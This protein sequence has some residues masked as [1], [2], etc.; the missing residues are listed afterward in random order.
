MNRRRRQGTGLF[1]ALVGGI[2]LATVSHVSQA[3]DPRTFLAG[4]TF[5]NGGFL[6]DPHRFGMRDPATD[7]VDQYTYTDNFDFHEVDLVTND[8]TGVPGG[9]GPEVNPRFLIY[10]DGDPN[11]PLLDREDFWE[12][13]V[14]YRAPA[15]VKRWVLFVGGAFPPPNPESPAAFATPVTV[16]WT[17]GTTQEHPTD[18]RLDLAA[19]PA[20]FQTVHMYQADLATTAI[21]TV[22]K[23]VDIGAEVAATRVDMRDTLGLLDPPNQYPVAINRP[24]ILVIE[25]KKDV[26]VIPE[27]EVS[28]TV[29]ITAGGA[30]APQAL[31]DA[32]FWRLVGDHL[33]NGTTG[34]LAPGDTVVVPAGDVTLVFDDVCGY[35][36][37]A[38]VPLTLTAL[39]PVQETGDYT[40]RTLGTLTVNIG[41]PEV[42]TVFVDDDPEVPYA[43]WEAFIPPSSSFQGYKASGQ[44]VSLCP[45]TWAVQFYDTV[46]GDWIAPADI[47][48]DIDY[49]DALVRNVVYTPK[50]IDVTVTITPQAAIDDGAQWTID[51]GATWHV[52]GAAGV[53]ATPLQAYTLAFRDVAGWTTPPN[54]P[55]TPDP[56]TPEVLQGDYTALADVTATLDGLDEFFVPGETVQ[57][58]GSFEYPGDQDLTALT[59]NF[60]LPTGWT[61]DDVSGDASV[62]DIAGDAIVFPAGRGLASNPVTFTATLTTSAA[63]TGDLD[64]GST[65]DYTPDFGGTPPIVLPAVTF[66]E[67]TTHPADT[68]H[69][70]KIKIFEYLVYAG[71]VAAV[72]QQGI[73]GGEY[74]W[75][76]VTLTPKT[77][78]GGALGT[79]SR[80]ATVDV[81][82][83]LSGNVFGAGTVLTVTLQ[84]TVDPGGGVALLALEEQLP[85]GWTVSSVGGGGVYN[86]V[87]NRVTWNISS[88]ATT[89][90]TYD[91]T[92]PAADLAD[93]YTITGQAGYSTGGASIDV[94][95]TDSVLT[96]LMVHPADT[97]ADFKIKIFEYLVY[98]GPVAAVFQQGINGGEYIWDGT[99]LT[100]KAAR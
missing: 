99:T 74:W 51:G 76:G 30:A 60:A 80:D 10:D 9:A 53:Q 52:S 77:G 91:I 75:D 79:R 64:V 4:L 14:D 59:W 45:G 81:S 29:D 8:D 26:T 88:P 71:P 92:A 89:A 82:R 67:L 39:Q 56:G 35:D 21:N 57:V 37:P 11:Y 40:P 16:G 6:G 33:D 17:I 47:Q 31:L 22:T 34:P 61:L 86:D 63:S 72:F 27:G 28:V 12:L 54:Q 65:A 24:T 49:D 62:A 70:N 42:L 5:A 98:A 48:V 85:D 2:C 15:D 36:K 93:Q 43:A 19:I 25:V 55:F 83:E 3:Q 1:L 78:R 94:S 66:K 23:Q 13:I 18:P 50:D 41:P 90:I 20:Y 32:A 69:D 38:D 97:N 58:A 87:D 44:S 7:G 68:N 84:V 100:P 96:K 95:T 73:N 46:D